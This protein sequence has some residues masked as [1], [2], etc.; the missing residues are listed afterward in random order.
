MGIYKRKN[1]SSNTRACKTIW[2]TVLLAATCSFGT[3]SS[4]GI[5]SY[6]FCTPFGYFC[7]RATEIPQKLFDFHDQN[8]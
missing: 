8:K 5:E 6:R 7:S 2:D 4:V 1:S 3:V